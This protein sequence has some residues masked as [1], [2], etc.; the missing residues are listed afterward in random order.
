MPTIAPPSTAPTAR[1][2]RKPDGYVGR[3]HETIG[4]DILAVLSALRMPGE[5]L[6]ADA[7]SRLRGID[8]DAWYP[9]SWLFE[10][11]EQIDVRV[12]RFGLMQGGRK[13]F[14][15]S[16]ETYARQT[17]HAARDVVYGIDAMY[18]RVNRGTGIGG[19]EVMAFTPGRAE[20]KKT[21]PHHCVMVE[22]ILLEALASLG[23]PAV[24]EQSTCLRRD[25]APHCVFVI[26]SALVDRRWS[27]D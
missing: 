17:L 23:V 6:G 20:L 10:L 13:V 24:I 1:T 18:H 7:A 11:T 26:T 16:H 5:V 22:G 14:K 8:P 2:T 12:G 25:E 9:A 27:G 15:K 19:W 3:D 21:T 4:S